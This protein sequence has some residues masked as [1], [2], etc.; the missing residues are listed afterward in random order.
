MWALGRTGKQGLGRAKSG[1]KV[2]NK[3]LCAEVVIEFVWPG[4]G[5]R[6]TRIF[7]V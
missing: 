2:I 5:E 4:E 1:V 7:L 3:K 6:N